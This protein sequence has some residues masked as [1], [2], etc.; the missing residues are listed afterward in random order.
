[1][2]ASGRL[3]RQRTVELLTLAASE[4]RGSRFLNRGAPTLLET[5]MVLFAREGEIGRS[6]LS[7][8][9]RENGVVSIPFDDRHLALALDAFARYGKGRHPAKLNYGDCMTYAT[10][11]LADRPLLFLGE[12]FAKTD[13]RRA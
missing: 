5:A 9:L 1:M 13:L 6:A 12:D 7:L 8:F 3:D 10:A 11:R 2:L 4:P